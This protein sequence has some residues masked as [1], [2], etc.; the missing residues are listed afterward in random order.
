MSGEQA[1]GAAPKGKNK[2]TNEDVDE[3]S[4]TLS[5]TE[6]AD[7]KTREDNEGKEEEQTSETPPPSKGKGT[8][9]TGKPSARRKL[10]PL[11]SAVP[12]NSSSTN[13][14]MDDK[15]NDGKWLLDHPWEDKTPDR[16]N[17]KISNT[18]GKS[19]NY[20]VADKWKTANKADHKTI[21]SDLPVFI[22]ER[23]GPTCRPGLEDISESKLCEKQLASSKNPHVQ[24]IVDE[25]KGNI[26]KDKPSPKDQSLKASSLEQQT[27]HEPLKEYTIGTSTVN[28]C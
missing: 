23:K 21:Y 4:K 12:S 7:T 27:Y 28:T 24:E 19:A 14:K 25:K 22:S 2:V 13:K 6:I 20:T 9:T 15:L 16:Q 10:L 8:G 18:I 26:P 5:K 3:L 17:L 1:N 11:D